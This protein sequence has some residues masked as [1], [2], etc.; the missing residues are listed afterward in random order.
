[1]K[2]TASLLVALAGLLGAL[3]CDDDN[4][5]GDE[6]RCH[7]GDYCYLGCTGP[8]CDLSC[9]SMPECGGICEDDCRFSCNDVSHCS[10][11]CDDDCDIACDR[12]SSCGAVCGARCNYHCAGADRCGVEVGPESV[13]DC[14]GVSSCVVECRGSCT[15]SCQGVSAD[16]CRVTCADGTTRT[17]TNGEIQCSD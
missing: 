16:Q 9:A 11:L 10:A 7:S 2:T 8:G 1:M 14:S 15:V 17:T 13:V 6:C 5:E 4:C 3:A 12:L